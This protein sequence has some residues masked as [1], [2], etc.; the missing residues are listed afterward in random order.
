M[1]EIFCVTLRTGCV[2]WKELLL[3]VQLGYATTK[4]ATN[5]GFYQ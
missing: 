2:Y 1:A 5:N 4:D 3:Q